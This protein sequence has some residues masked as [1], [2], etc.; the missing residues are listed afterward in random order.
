SKIPSILLAAE[1]RAEEMGVMARQAWDRYFSEEQ[2]F[3]TVVDWCLQIVEASRGRSQLEKYV[4][5][6]QLMHPFY[7]RHEVLASI[8]RLLLQTLR[9]KTTQRRSR[10]PGDAIGS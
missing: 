4:A 10:L 1:N 5:L 2:A 3:Q 6:L 8:K 9:L 7:F